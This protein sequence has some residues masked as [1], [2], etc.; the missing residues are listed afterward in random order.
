MLHNIC[1][2]R[3]WSLM[4]TPCDVSLLKNAERGKVAN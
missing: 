2:L 3:Y 4:L 1:H